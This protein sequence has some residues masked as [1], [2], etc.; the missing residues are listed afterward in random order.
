MNR[1]DALTPVEQ[2]AYVRAVWREFK[3]TEAHDVLMWWLHELHRNAK[4]VVLNPDANPRHCL[5]AIGQEQVLEALFSKM[6]EV[7]D[8]RPA[9]DGLDVGADEFAEALPDDDLT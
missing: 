7:V 4:R 3:A 5:M 8:L 6:E 9:P 2:V 1:L